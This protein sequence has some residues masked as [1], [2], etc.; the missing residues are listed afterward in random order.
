MTTLKSLPKTPKKDFLKSMKGIAK[1]MLGYNEKLKE[2]YGDK[3]QIDLGYL[4][5]YATSNPDLIKHIL[6]TN[7]KNYVK[8]MGYDRLKMGL[9]DGLLTSAGD[10]WRKQR[11]LSQPVFYK[12]NLEN[13]FVD[14]GRTTTEF[15]D[16]MEQL[17]GSEI[18][19]S[20]LM[21]EITA[22]IVLRSLFNVEESQQLNKIYESM[23]V[24]QN[25]IMKHV[26][27]PIFSPFYYL[28]SS[29]REFKVS[30]KDM[31]DLVY[32]MIHDRQKSGKKKADLLQMLMDV[33][34]A[35]TGE[36]M[37]DLQL[38]DEL[39]TLF[40]AG[41]ETSA[42]S[43]G[44]T[45]YMLA[46]HPEIVEKI[47]AEV[48]DVLPNKEMPTFEQVRQLT[49]TEQV[50]NEGMRLFPPAW[51]IGRR[52]VEDDE[53]E[54]FEIKKEINILCEIY[55]LHRSEAFWDNPEEFNPD[56][57]SA[58]AVKARPRHHFIPFGAGPRMCIGNHFAMIEMQLLLSTIVQRFDFSVVENHPVELNG[59]LTLRP[60]Y[61]IKL[62]IK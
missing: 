26:Q 33:E 1:D 11:R 4:Q 51:V 7:H 50:I 61:G 54:G 45:F 55:L 56:R 17:R 23:D 46:Q 27:N 24:M 25:Y 41:H 3:Y 49:Y 42:N 6:Q 13:L 18:D 40:S 9:G 59:L 48:D 8:S 20:K 52:A 19:I 35:D 44:W 62:K 53:F 38:R 21:T 12:N 15:L 32:G 34:D 2:I 60:K 5:L 37:T 10:Y 36:K 28:S 14:M 30:M 43:L 16:T 29:H 31:D 22:T 58:E 57:F 39:I 47:R